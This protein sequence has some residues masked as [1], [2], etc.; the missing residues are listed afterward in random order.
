MMSAS[1]AT[2]EMV[3]EPVRKKRRRHALLYHGFGCHIHETRVPEDP[4]DQSVHLQVQ[5]HVGHAD[6]DTIAQYLL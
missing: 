2:P 4:A 5:V 3:T 1:G 6:S